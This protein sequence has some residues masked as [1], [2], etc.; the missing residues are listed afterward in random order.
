MSGGG[1]SHESDEANRLADE[2]LRLQKEELEQKR[3]AVFKERMA[4][5]Q[6]QGAQQFNNPDNPNPPQQII[7]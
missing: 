6:G 1:G 2:Q 5:L 3:E 7:Q 4:I